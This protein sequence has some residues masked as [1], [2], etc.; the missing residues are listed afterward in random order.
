MLEK[1]E[2]VLATKL[3]AI[4]ADFKEGHDAN[5]TIHL[6][7]A[8]FGPDA[9]ARWA[10]SAARTFVRRRKPKTAKAAKAAEISHWLKTLD[11][12]G[13]AALLERAKMLAAGQGPIETTETPKCPTS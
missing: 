5:L 6:L 13:L 2:N 9:V 7:A 4:V 3:D 10:L 11:E 1:D 12:N 8:T